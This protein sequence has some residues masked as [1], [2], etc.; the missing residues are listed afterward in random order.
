MFSEYYD[1]F[2]RELLGLAPLEAKQRS[3]GGEEFELLKDW[4]VAAAVDDIQQSYALV[5][6][7]EPIAYQEG[8]A[9]VV[10]FLCGDEVARKSKRTFS[11]QRAHVFKDGSE[12]PDLQK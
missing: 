6:T 10:R 7:L 1:Q 9:I 3:V 5:R 4:D 12:L 8:V 2:Q 11:R